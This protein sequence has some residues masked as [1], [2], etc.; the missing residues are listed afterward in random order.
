MTF[1]EIV[2]IALLVNLPW[3]FFAIGFNYGLKKSG[4]LKRFN[5]SNY[6]YLKRVILE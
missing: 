2:L 6:K 1:L 3:L 4:E 5:E